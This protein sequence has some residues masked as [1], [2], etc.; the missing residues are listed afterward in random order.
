[1]RIRGL[2][3]LLTKKQRQLIGAAF[4]FYWLDKLFITLHAVADA[5]P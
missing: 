1:M 4:L 3:P 2:N 5:V